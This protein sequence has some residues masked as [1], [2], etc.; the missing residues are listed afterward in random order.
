MHDFVVVGIGPSD[1]E[2][3]REGS[4]AK[5]SSQLDHFPLLLWRPPNDRNITPRVVV[6]S[7]ILAQLHCIHAR[8]GLKRDPRDT[9]P[10]GYSHLAMLV[11]SRLRRALSADTGYRVFSMVSPFP[12]ALTSDRYS[13]SIRQCHRCI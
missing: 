7:A 13:S 4:H 8:S 9:Q 2:L 12:G 6:F 10:T 3:M 1:W 11:Y 5:P